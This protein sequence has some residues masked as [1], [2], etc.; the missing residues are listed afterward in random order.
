MNAVA[1]GRGGGLPEFG[2]RVRSP[3]TWA[4]FTAAAIA[5][6]ASH[7]L[8]VMFK[9]RLS[10]GLSFDPHDMKVYFASSRW[11]V[12]SALFTYLY[13]VCAVTTGTTMLPHWLGGR[14]P[15]FAAHQP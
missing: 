11:W 2:M 8:T 10:I 6:A 14:S 4:F 15:E 5:G 3:I 1:A 9:I 13:A 7:Y 12:A